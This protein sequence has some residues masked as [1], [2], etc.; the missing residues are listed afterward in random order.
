MV[1]KAVRKKTGEE[2]AVKTFKRETLTE[3]DELAL[4]NE[5]DILSQVLII[6]ATFR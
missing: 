6:F 5:V 2:V 4:R 1:R 3:D